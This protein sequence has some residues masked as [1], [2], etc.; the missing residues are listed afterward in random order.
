MNRICVFFKFFGPNRIPFWF[1]RP[2]HTDEF[3]ISNRDW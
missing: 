1:L 3:D 2:S